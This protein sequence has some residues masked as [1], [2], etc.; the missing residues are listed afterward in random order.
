MQATNLRSTKRHTHAAPIAHPHAATSPHP[1]AGYQ[2]AQ[3]QAAGP[4]HDPGQRAAHA[5]AGGWGL[6][7]RTAY[8]GCL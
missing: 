2:P 6:Q 1:A 8:W 7:H 3:H 4:P 5:P